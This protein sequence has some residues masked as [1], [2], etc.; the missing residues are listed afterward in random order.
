MAFT[1]GQIDTDAGS[2]TARFQCT[3]AEAD[4]LNGDIPAFAMLE[5]PPVLVTS[6]VDDA[7]PDE[8]RLDAYFDEKPGQQQLRLILSLLPSSGDQSLPKPEYLQPEDWVTI[9][10]QGLEPV[11]AGRFY[12]Y[13]SSET[14]CNDAG[15]RNL[16][17]DPAQAFGTGHHETTHGCLEMLDRLER[18]GAR[19]S[20]IAD[21]GTG[22]G[23]L[24]FAAQHLWPHSAII[25]SDIDAL[26]V[27]VARRYANENDIGQGRGRGRLTLVAANGTDHRLIVRRSPYD[28][29]IANILAG[30]L[31]DLAPA[32][33]RAVE[34]GGTLILAGLLRKQ[35]GDIGRAYRAE[36]FRLAEIC[37]NG[38]W[39]TLRFVKRR[40]YGIKR[41]SRR[42]GRTSQPPGDFGEC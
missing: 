6:E 25:A 33:G 26:A 8:W 42:P 28:L 34:E 32:F 21:I 20:N 24:A 7:K 10:Q 9:S 22:T 16:R 41:I 5:N 37:E 39:P 14:V 15:V 2:W 19:F 36:G 38:D 31:T 17:I 12:V 11:R 4:A 30:P 40:R 35:R 27:D 29:L 1:M 18:S 3:R 13:S 23:L